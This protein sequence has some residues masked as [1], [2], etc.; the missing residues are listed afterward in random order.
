MEMFMY[1]INVFKKVLKEMRFIVMIFFIIKD[2]F[3][4]IW[5][6]FGKF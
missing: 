4:I 2:Y 1:C 6:L 3:M 5:R